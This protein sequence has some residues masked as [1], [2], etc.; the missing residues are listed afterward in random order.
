MGARTL[1]VTASHLLLARPRHCLIATHGW[2]RGPPYTISSAARQHCIYTPTVYIEL[3]GRRHA[4]RD[5]EGARENGGWEGW[6]EPGAEGREEAM[7]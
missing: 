6:R 3:A 2:A 1:N 4:A 7:M 5:R